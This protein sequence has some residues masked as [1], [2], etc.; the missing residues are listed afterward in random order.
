MSET[1]LGPSVGTPPDRQLVGGALALPTGRRRT[2]APMLAAQA[3]RPASYEAVKRGVALS[4]CK[5]AAPALGIPR[6]VVDL[7]DYLVGRTLEADWLDGNRPLAWPSNFTLQDALGLGR[8]QVKTL[9]RVALEYGLIEMADSPNGHRYGRREGARV[10]EAFGFDLS[11]LAARHAEFQAIAAAHAERR[12]EGR[13]LRS[14]ITSLR[15]QVLSLTDAAQELGRADADWLALASQA[16][17]RAEQ[18]GDS[19]DPGQLAP[20][21]ARL[22]ALHAKVQA[23]LA[24]SEAVE[25]DPKGPENRPHHTPT[26]SPP[27]AEATTAADGPGQPSAQEEKRSPLPSPTEIAA[28]PP[29]RATPDRREERQSALRGFV[30]TPKLILKIAPAFRGWVRSARPGWGELIEAA[31][32]VR[33]D[34]GVS[35]HAWGQA[36]VVLGRMEAVTVLAVIAAR[37][38]AGKV[39]SPGG[40]LRRMVELHQEGRL[41]LDRTL[42]GLAD[43]LDARRH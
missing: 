10:V 19:Y 4:A 18:R 15:N 2:T 39:R 35:Q 14:R 30:V 8:T 42:F 17:Q 16:R 13:R 12:R 33:S 26:N 38:A 34:L 27:L 32:L 22:V 6:R 37:H 23:A 7:I 41:R 3:A 21:V 1:A 5:R 29:A 28:Q 20:I 36:C 11:P 25:T 31:W 9:V 43:G 40:L 24:Q